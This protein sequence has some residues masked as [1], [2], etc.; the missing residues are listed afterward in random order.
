MRGTETKMLA[1]PLSPLVDGDSTGAPVPSTKA[2]P[3]SAMGSL[4][5]YC[6]CNTIGMPG[7]AER[8]ITSLASEWTRDGHEVTLVTLEPWAGLEFPIDSGV[9][10]VRLDFTEGKG[11]ILRRAAGQF[12]KVRRLYEIFRR[13]KPSVVVSFMDVANV[14]SIVA[15]RLSGTPVIACQRSSALGIGQPSGLRWRMLRR[16][17]YPLAAIVTVQTAGLKDSWRR[18]WPRMNICVMP[19]P[20]SPPLASE[21]PAVYAESP[22][23]RRLVATGRL[24]EVKGFDLLIDAFAPLAARFPDWD[25]WIW[26]DGEGGPELAAKAAKLGLQ[27]RILMPG[28]TTRPWLEMAKADIFVLSSRN[29]GFPNALVEAMALG[30]P[31]V[32]FDCAYG[33]REITSDGQDGILV[34]AGD[35]EA[36]RSSLAGL[37]SDSAKRKSLSL[38]ALRVRERYAPEPIFRLWDGLLAA[39]TQR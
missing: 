1:T 39:V 19:N 8:V 26:G 25:L 21:P 36:L 14:L 9:A 29:E 5:I 33:P 32:A 4:R 34:S 30:R 2:M 3:Q 23:R 15:G 31:C 11:G 35:V 22:G 27:D 10:R 17:I 20:I 13:E 12:G 24:V 6:I 38:R 7:G 37:M 28:L 18:Q 16:F